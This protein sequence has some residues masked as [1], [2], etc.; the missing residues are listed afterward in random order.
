MSLLTFHGLVQFLF[1]VDTQLT[2]SKL[3]NLPPD[4][5]SLLFRG[6][7]K[8]DN[9]VLS[10]AGV[11]NGDLASSTEKFELD[12]VALSHSTPLFANACDLARKIPASLHSPAQ[13]SIRV[14]A[15]G[16]KCGG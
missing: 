8:A 12:T 4:G 1:V 11:K 16:D 3:F 15:P 2:A 5:I 6:R 14:L 9:E 10:L 13:D 7:K